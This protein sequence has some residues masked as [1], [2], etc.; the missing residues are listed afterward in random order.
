MLVSFACTL[1]KIYVANPGVDAGKS[2]MLVSISDPRLTSS[3][4][5]K[6]PF[7]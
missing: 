6:V 2:T 3:D 4:T 1:S 5:S 7:H